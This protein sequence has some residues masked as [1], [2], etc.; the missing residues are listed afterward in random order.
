MTKIF[1][2]L[3]ILFGI[4]SAALAQYGSK[5]FTR[6]DTVWTICYFTTGQKSTEVYDL[7]SDTRWHTLKAY[8]KNGKVI[9]ERSY[10]QKHGSSGVELKYHPNGG[11]SS[12]RYT[13]QPDGGIQ[14]TDITTYFTADGRVD[15][16]VDM[17]IGDNGMMHG[18][19]II[20]T[21]GPV[22]APHV[23]PR[24][25]PKPNECAPVP[26]ATEV[27]LINYTSE[28]LHIRAQYKDIAAGPAFYDIE[29][30]D[31]VKMGIHY[32]SSAANPLDHYKLQVETQARY[33]FEYRVSNGGGNG[34][35]KQYVMVTCRKI[36]R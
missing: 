2:T 36:K 30:S 6:K 3:A 25:A 11:I 22:P 24:P 21:K 31:T 32:A 12:A 9:Y 13:M 29:P 19:G 5:T 20:T 16:E 23:T 15:H 7:A 17:S 26:A 4:S 28:R 18:P 14:H 8:D 27:Y 33:D 35:N 10:G 1:F 34:S